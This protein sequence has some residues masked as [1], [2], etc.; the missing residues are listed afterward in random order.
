[1]GQITN[2]GRIFDSCVFLAFL[3]FTGGF[4]LFLFGELHKMIVLTEAKK[5]GLGAAI[6]NKMF[7]FP[8]KKYEFNLT[9]V[10]LFSLLIAL[11]SMVHHPCQDTIEQEGEKEAKKAAK[12]KH[13]E[14]KDAE[15]A[16]KKE[17]ENA[18]KNK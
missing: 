1:M 9:H 4:G 7:P 3:L 15:K 5:L 6:F 16:A 12:R 8:D 18:G 14:Q 13:N 10:I 11:L 17:K 2:F